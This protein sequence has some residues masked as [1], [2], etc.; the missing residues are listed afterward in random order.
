MTENIKPV[1]LLTVADLA[2]HPVWEYVNVDELFDP[3]VRPV[4]EIPV[5]SFLHKEIGA[6]VRLANGLLVWALIANVDATDPRVAEHFAA[7][8]IERR[9]KWF[10]LA[11]YHD[12]NFATQG[13]EAL[14]R[15][16]GLSV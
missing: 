13:P 4:K 15:F 12:F 9:G 11:R 6:Q 16:L 10:H 1:E 7:L 5:E 14:A 3:L 8:S 2:A